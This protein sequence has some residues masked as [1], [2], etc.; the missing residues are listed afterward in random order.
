MSRICLQWKDSE[1]FMWR[2]LSYW[3]ALIH[4]FTQSVVGCFLGDTVFMESSVQHFV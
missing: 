2:S 4:Y 3:S 1:D